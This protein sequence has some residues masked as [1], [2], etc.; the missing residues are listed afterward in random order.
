[1]TELG[2][3]D[4]APVRALAALACGRIGCVHDHALLASPRATSSSR[5]ASIAV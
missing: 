3:F 4:A 5:S 1:M 2:C